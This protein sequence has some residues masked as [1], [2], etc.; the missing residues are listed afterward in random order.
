MVDANWGFIPQPLPVCIGMIPPL[1]K[2]DTANKKER[3]MMAVNEDNRCN[4][5]VSRGDG[6]DIHQGLEWWDRR[7]KSI[8]FLI[9]CLASKKAYGNMR[10]YLNKGK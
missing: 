5:I 8:K 6:K 2:S 7:Y 9:N 10:H 4:N 1:S 3:T